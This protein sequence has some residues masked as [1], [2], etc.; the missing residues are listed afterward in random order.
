MLSQHT[1]DFAVQQFHDKHTPIKR[2]LQQ[3]VSPSEQE[4]KKSH[5]VG[6]GVG[7]GGGFGLVLAGYEANMLIPQMPS[8]VPLLRSM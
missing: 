8:A 6:P 5:L 4:L 2:Q 3:Q 7:G 1:A